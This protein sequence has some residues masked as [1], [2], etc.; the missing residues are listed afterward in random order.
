MLASGLSF[1]WHARVEQE[2]R[3]THRHIVFL[4]ESFDLNEA[5]ITP[6]SDEVGDD[7]ERNGA[8]NR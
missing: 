4:E 3:K 1:W 8:R 5:D 7:D 6:R 2:R